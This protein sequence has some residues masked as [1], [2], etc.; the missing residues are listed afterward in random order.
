LLVAITGGLH[1]LGSVSKTVHLLLGL[2]LVGLFGDFGRR[3]TE[4][5]RHLFLFNCYYF[6]CHYF[7]FLYLS[8]DLIAFSLKGRGS[9]DNLPLKVIPGVSSDSA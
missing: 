6:L 1:L 5:K 2:L 9:S 8:F 4:R 7:F 3:L